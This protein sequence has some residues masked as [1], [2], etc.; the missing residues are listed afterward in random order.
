MKKLPE[1]EYEME[2]LDKHLNIIYGIGRG[3]I[4]NNRRKNYNAQ[5]P[6]P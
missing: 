3:Y 4:P 5:T 1:F 2:A 6:D